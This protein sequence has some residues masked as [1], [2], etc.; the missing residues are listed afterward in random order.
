MIVS[1]II[2]S[3]LK[4]HYSMIV[5]IA[6]VCVAIGCVGRYLVGDD[7]NLALA[8]SI[9]VAISHVPIITAPYG[10]LGLF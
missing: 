5:I 2:F 8:F 6:T 1:P 10:L 9:L 3:W 4:K 7:Y